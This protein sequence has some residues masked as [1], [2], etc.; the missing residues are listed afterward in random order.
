MKKVLKVLL[1]IMIVGVL[2]SCSTDKNDD[3][4]P[5][6]TDSPIVLDCNYFEE[7]RVLTK[8]PN[9]AVDYL[10]KCRMFVAGHIVI[11]PGVVIEFEK[12][13]GIS[14]SDKNTA[15]FAAKGTAEKPII[16][17]G[18]EKEKGFW[19]GIHFYSDNAN[20]QLDYVYV[21]DAGGEPH[22][23]RGERSAIFLYGNGHLKL[24]NSVISNS[25]SYGLM[26][27]S[28]FLS[29]LEIKNTKFNNNQAPLLIEAD[30][31]DALESTNDYSGNTENFA[32]IKPTP[33]RKPTV[34]KK[35]NVPYRVVIDVISSLNF[36]APLVVEPGVVVEFEKGMFV[37]VDA[38]KGSVKI[39]GKPAD[40]IIFT[41]IDKT[42]GGWSGLSFDSK[43]PS[44]EIAFTEFHYS[45]SPIVDPELHPGTIRLGYEAVLNIHDVTFKDIINCALI[46]RNPAGLTINN[47]TIDPNA[48][49]T[50][51]VP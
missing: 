50:K 41:G 8:N 32:Y 3:G 9:A 20:N 43:N 19:R 4:P 44:N 13:T 38:N 5:V 35:I 26:S 34:W 2:H 33:V 7:D 15:S 30:H 18:V 16:F 42:I 22:T 40:P 39:I 36:E 49:L 29:V 37:G 31:L 1:L 24:T 23:N 6:Y 11:E 21:E 14:Q 46:V 27:S 45:G 25:K 48:C 12:D 28:N 17:R 51:V 10:V 47:I